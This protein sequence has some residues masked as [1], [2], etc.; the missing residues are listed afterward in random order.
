MIDLI[1]VGQCNLRRDEGLSAAL[2]LK[3]EGFI[4]IGIVVDPHECLASA[5]DQLIALCRGRRRSDVE[6]ACKPLCNRRLAC[7]ILTICTQLSHSLAQD[8]VHFV[9]VGFLTAAFGKHLPSVDDRVSVNFL[10]LVGTERDGCRLTA[11]PRK[12]KSK[13]RKPCADMSN[14]PAQADVMMP[15][16]FNSGKHSK[17][18]KG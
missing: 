3:R 7:G 5:E 12:D 13:K 18:C 9:A 1:T 17:R 14:H 15:K 4:A 8:T 10:R 11:C 2:R 6:I 16:R